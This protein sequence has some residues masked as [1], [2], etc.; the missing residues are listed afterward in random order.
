MTQLSSVFDQLS[1]AFPQLEWQRGALLAPFTYMKIGGPAEVLWQATDRDELCSV[2]QFCRE[3]SV[4]TTILGGGSNV[5]LPDEG[6]AGLVIINETSELEHFTSLPSELEQFSKPGVEGYVMS[7]SGV[8]T[9][10][11]VRFAVD[12]SLAGLEPFLGVPGTVGGATVNNSHYTDEL[13]GDFIVAVEVLDD[14][15]KRM[16]LSQADCAF[17]YDHSRFHVTDEVVIRVLFALQQGEQA[18]SME[19]IRS[20]TVKR[21]TTQPLGTANSGCMFKNVTLPE[22]KRAE[23]DG[24][25]SLSAGW[26]IDQSGLKGERVGRIVV[27]DKHANFFINEGN[28][29]AAQVKELVQKVQVAVNAKFG[30]ELQPEVFFLS[31]EIK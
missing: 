11:L 3:N 30:L 6:L 5:L 15:G 2:L 14:T 18:V 27:S 13:I 4:E 10:L 28:G 17:A 23:Y 9:A 19:K 1:A 24:K 29:T 26:L 7:D 31:G 21:A 20:A 8:K 16:W 12:H 22:E 25:S